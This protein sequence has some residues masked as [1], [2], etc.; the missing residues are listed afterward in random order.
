MLCVIFSFN[1]IEIANCCFAVIGN[2]PYSERFCNNFPFGTPGKDP[3]IYWIIPCVLL[4]SKHFVIK[5]GRE[6]GSS[7]SGND[8]A[9]ITLFIF[10]DVSKGGISYQKHFKSSFF[11]GDS[12]DIKLFCWTQCFALFYTQFENL[13]DV[14]PM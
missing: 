4:Q 8:L 7:L 1:G 3:M 9:I 12:A 5:A 10:S 14:I 6:R 13:N 2:C 11:A